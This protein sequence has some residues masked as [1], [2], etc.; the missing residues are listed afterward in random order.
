MRECGDPAARTAGSTKSSSPRTCRLHDLG[1]AHSI[2]AWQDD[3]LAGGVYGVRVGR[4]FAGESMFHRVTDA[5]KVALWARGGAAARS[6]GVDA[7]RRAV[8]D[9]AP[10]VTGRGRRSQRGVFAAAR[11]GGRVER[12]VTRRRRR[13]DLPQPVVLEVAW[14]ARDPAGA[15]RRRRRREVPRHAAGPEDARTHPR[16][17]RRRADRARPHR[18]PEVQGRRTQQGRREDAQAGRRRAARAPRGD[19]AA[20]GLRRRPRGDRP[21]VRA[22]AGTARSGALVGGRARGARAGGAGAEGLRRATSTRRSRRCAPTVG[23]ASAASKPNSGTAKSGSV[24]CRARARAPTSIATRA[25]RCTA[26]PPTPS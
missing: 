2:E 5:S 9:A 18:R 10:G 4:L 24:R 17:D 12:W 25:S 13:E 14:R 8:D 16:R 1:W 26:R 23:H 19:G 22:S 7:V 20:G 21:A 15:R 3:V 6:D 11:R